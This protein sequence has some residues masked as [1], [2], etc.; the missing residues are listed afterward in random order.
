MV[1]KLLHEYEHLIDM[2][3]DA[4]FEPFKGDDIIGFNMLGEEEFVMPNVV[5]FRANFNTIPQ[6]TDFPITDLTFPI[7]SNR[8][9]TILENVKPFKKRVL[10]TIMVD[11]TYLGEYLNKKGE[12]LDGVKIDSSYY[13]VQFLEFTDAFDKN[14][15]IYKPMRSNPDMPGVI[16]K[17]VLKEPQNGFP[18]MFKI[19]ENLSLTFISEEAR[20]ALESNHIKGCVFEEVEVS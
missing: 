5:Y 12:V 1:Y 13:G 15:S 11:D 6:N 4:S 2:D 8:M 19:K 16:K 7:I 18:S 10:K 20:I 14:N 9:I 3:F 17:L